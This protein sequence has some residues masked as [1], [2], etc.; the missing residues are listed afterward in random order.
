L[1]EEYSYEKQTGFKTN[2]FDVYRVF[3]G[4]FADTDVGD[5]SS[6]FDFDFVGFVRPVDVR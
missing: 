2:N 6:R 4:I 5:E 1:K 3:N